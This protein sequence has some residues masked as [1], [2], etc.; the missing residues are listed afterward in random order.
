MNIYG[1]S[2]SDAEA[3][4]EMDEITIRGN[5]KALRAMAQLLLSC[6][7]KMD[8]EVEWDHKHLQDEWNE[9]REAMP[10]LVVVNPK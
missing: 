6:A 9:W 4:L 3:L 1:Y 5:S 10:D 8:Q 7:D 2:K